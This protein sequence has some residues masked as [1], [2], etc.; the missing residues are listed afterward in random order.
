MCLTNDS[1]LNLCL[2]SGNTRFELG[3]WQK[4]MDGL[5]EK[6]QHNQNM[7]R[8]NNFNSKLIVY[9]DTILF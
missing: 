3:N 4:A 1:K 2:N 9:I 8:F 5:N 7:Y 6:I